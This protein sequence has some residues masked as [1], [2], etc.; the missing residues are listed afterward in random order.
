V[1]IVSPYLRSSK[2]A[3]PG[4]RKLTDEHTDQFVDLVFGGTKAN[5][6]T[7]EERVDDQD[8]SAV[9]HLVDDFPLNPVHDLFN[10]TLIGI[11]KTGNGQ[12]HI[13]NRYNHHMCGNSIVACAV[14]FRSKFQISFCD[15][16]IDLT[17]APHG[18]DPK[19]ILRG[20]PH[21]GTHKAYPLLFVLQQTLPEVK[22]LEKKREVRLG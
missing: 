20:T 12:Y 10:S 15:R 1:K 21:I 2:S 5:A 14:A 9:H 7:F 13:S 19:D 17:G 8:N 11:F 6:N 22:L 16:K 3:P 18:V 4:L